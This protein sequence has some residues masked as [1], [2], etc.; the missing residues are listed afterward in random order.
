M[1]APTPQSRIETFDRYLEQTTVDKFVTFANRD[2]GTQIWASQAV[3][4]QGSG[5]GAKNSLWR[6]SSPEEPRERSHTYV[7]SGHLS[8]EQTAVP[9]HPWRGDVSV[10]APSTHR[11]ICCFSNRTR[12]V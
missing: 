6:S 4:K 7:G 8:D 3:A 12:D 9:L 10:V 5:H 11:L 2:L 1:R